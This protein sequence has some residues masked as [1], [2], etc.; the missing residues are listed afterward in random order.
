MDPIVSTAGAKNLSY[1]I[2][3]E[4]WVNDWDKLTAVVVAQSDEMAGPGLAALK[5]AD[6]RCRNVEAFSSGV[7]AFDGAP[8]DLLVIQAIGADPDYLW[9]F[10]HRLRQHAQV[11]PTRVVAA[12]TLKEVDVVAEGLFD[13]RSEI[14]CDPTVQEYSDAILRLGET[15]A[16]TLHD[17]S[18]GD[19]LQHIRSEVDR[20]A[21]ALREISEAEQIAPERSASITPAAIRQMIWERR[22]RE[23]FFDADLF[24]DPAWDMLLDLFLGD[25]ERRSICVSSLCIAAA[26]P[27]T[28]ALRWIGNM[29]D[30]GLFER[31]PDPSDRRRYFLRLSDKARGAMLAYCDAL[32][33]RRTA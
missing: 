13:I 11:H 31:Y 30:A 27:P 20:L 4:N 28:T 8:F 25:L 15:P 24:A 33:T 16:R 23:R 6:V 22:E 12:V 3:E 26:T 17:R 2:S 14:L 1:R 5:A 18:S 32:N 7:L 21:A 29:T 10:L 9:D 19:R